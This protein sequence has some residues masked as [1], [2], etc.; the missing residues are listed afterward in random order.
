MKIKRKDPKSHFGAQLHGVLG[1]VAER[2]QHVRDLSPKEKQERLKQI[3][4]YLSTECLGKDPSFFMLANFALDELKADRALRGLEFDWHA[5]DALK[6]CGR[7]RHPSMFKHVKKL[8]KNNKVQRG[9]WLRNLVEKILFAF[10]PVAVGTGLARHS[11]KDGVYFV[12][13]AQHRM[14]ACIMFGIRWLPLEWEVS[15]DR[16]IDVLQYSRENMGS[17]PSTRF[18]EYRTMVAHVEIALEEDPDFEASLFGEEY[19]IVWNVHNIFADNDARFIEKGG[20]GKHAAKKLECTGVGN[21]ITHY[22]NYGKDLVQRSVVIHVLAFPKAPIAANNIL[23]IC[24]FIETQENNNV[25]NNDSIAVDDAIVTTLRHSMGKN[26]TRNGFYKD[27]NTAINDA[28]KVDPDFPTISYELRW[29]AGIQ[30]SIQI[31]SPTVSWADVMLG[32]KVIAD[33]YLDYFIVPNLP[34][35]R[36]ALISKAAKKLEKA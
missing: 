22:G 17:L 15:E 14:L 27:V 3:P 8:V 25:L 31:T 30:K 5:E 12:N 33:E 6:H 4:V 36:I 13:D 10:D 2:K 21:V 28:A 24:E 9:I 35:P 20:Q 16:V 1:P 26:G 7:V 19:E 11:V 18:D 32:S 34:T 23:G 29:A